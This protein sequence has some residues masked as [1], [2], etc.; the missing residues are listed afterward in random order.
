MIKI[1]NE[2]IYIYTFWGNIDIEPYIL[3]DESEQT[4]RIILIY[5]RV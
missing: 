5:N 2:Y 1:S 3:F 4:K